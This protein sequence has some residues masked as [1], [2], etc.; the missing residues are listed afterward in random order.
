MPSNHETLLRQ[1][2]MLRWIPRYPAKITASQIKAKLDAEDLNVT[3]RTVE[4][5][6]VD[7]SLA[8]PLTVDDRSKPHGWSWQKDAPS[9]DLP[10]LGNNEALAMLM[11][12][13]YLTALL[14]AST[15]FVLEPHFKAARQHLSAIPKSAHVRAWPNKVR[16][17][18]PAQPLIAPAIKA[19]VHRAVSEAL[20]NEKQLQISYLK[21][22]ETEA[23]EYRVHPLALI[24]RG[25]LI[26]LLTRVFDYEDLRNLAMHRITSAEILD[27]ESHAPEGFD[28]D[29]EIAKGR[30]GFGD[31][32]MLRLKAKFTHESGEHLFETPLSEDQ[33]IQE[34]P[35]GDKIVTATLA[36]TPQLMWW[37]LG[38]GSGVE[39]LE[40]PELRAEIAETILQMHRVYQP[41]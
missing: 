34:M 36:D 8:F 15:R 23:N 1:W 40:P 38:M 32:S 24:Q 39:V 2:Q 16:T 17:V 21:R 29:T 37:L 28:I 27:A 10:G 41:D 22:G 14:P 11:V 3:K 4:R 31:G 13:Q 12:E 20:L 9:F 7:L 26:Y 5:D 30:F 25:G 18:P 19:E 33:Q 35:E 6:L